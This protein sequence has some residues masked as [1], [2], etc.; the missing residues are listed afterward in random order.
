MLTFSDGVFAIAMTLLVVTVIVPTVP[1]GSDDRSLGRALE[2][3]VPAFVSFVVS[4]AVIGRYWRAHHRFF[5]VLESMDSRLVNLNLV[6]LG[7]IAFVP[8]PTD[9]LGDHFG[10]LAVSFYAIV[11]ALVSAMEVVLFQSAH[12]AGL[13]RRDISSREY[14]WFVGMSLSPVVCFLASVPVAAVSPVLAVVVWFLP[15]AAHG[16]TRRRRPPGVED[17]FA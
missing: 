17:L 8:F 9:I 12:H 3:L 11:M 6:F 1:P 13:L 5:A 10:A 2:G 16:L 4:F 7:L 14:W 15:F